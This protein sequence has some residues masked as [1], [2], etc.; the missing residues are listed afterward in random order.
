MLGLIS[1]MNFDRR[2]REFGAD[3]RSKGF[4]SWDQFVS[5]L[6]CQMAQAKSLREICGGLKICLGKL[7]HLGVG[8]TPS[9]SN[10]SYAN[11]N[12]PWELYEAVFHDLLKTCR[13]SVPWN[14]RKF[15]FK[16]KLYSLDAT[17]IELCLGM[18][19]WAKYRTTK[20][21]VKLHMLLDHDIYMP[22]F[23][24]MTDGMTHEV[25]VAR[26]LRLPPD[27]IV[28]MDMGYNDYGMFH[29][30]TAKGIWFVTR[31]KD[32]ARF[33]VVAK[34]KLPVGK[35]HVLSDEMIEF[36]GFY[37]QK[38]CPGRLRRI[39]F[40]NEEKCEEMVFLTNNMKLAASTIAAIYKE[41]WQIEIFF[42]MLKQNLKVKTFVG[43]SANAVKIQ[44]WTALI[45]LLLIKY[46]Q[47]R[48]RFGWSMSNLVA[49]LRWNLFSYRELWGWLDDPFE[50]P[51]EQEYKQE[52][53]PLWDSIMGKT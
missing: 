51:P 6:F 13:G 36:V 3:Y 29:D 40:W 14:R 26:L 9:K 38:D 47:S 19:D 24:N 33:R 34:N 10:L 7:V 16:N 39:V 2:V 32:N 43:T 30:W 15:R 37:A 21:A 42:K 1:R 50:K 27:S 8:R 41:R 25:N 44:I 5:M 53:L 48:S 49:I 18:Y 28:A 46:L 35:K 45:A 4:S 12:R 52:E 11:R 23:V 31:Q 20:G 17:L 22:T